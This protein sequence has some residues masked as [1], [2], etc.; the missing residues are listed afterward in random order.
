VKGRVLVLFI[1][2]DWAEDHPDV[3]IQDETGRRPGTVRLPEGVEG[4]AKLHAFVAR[5]GGETLE[6]GQ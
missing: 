6:P 3:E 2:D 1:G 4:I 5:H